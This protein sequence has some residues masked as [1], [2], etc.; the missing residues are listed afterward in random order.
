MEAR[1]N[2]T[3]PAQ[4]Q[5]FLAIEEATLKE[6]GG[7]IGMHGINVV[8]CQKEIDDLAVHYLAKLGILAV[9][10]VKKSDLEALRRVTG[11]SLVSSPE[12]IVDSDLGIATSI[13]EESLESIVVSLF[14]QNT[15]LTVLSGVA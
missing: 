13:E 4:I 5:E 11:A 3:D 10:R 8:F 15:I 9:K 6:M 2:I 7:F 14:I 12:S 1:L